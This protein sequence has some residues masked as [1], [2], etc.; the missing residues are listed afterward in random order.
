MRL[1]TLNANL[2]A[3]IAA[4]IAFIISLIPIQIGP[5]FGVSIALVAIHILSFRRGWK[6][7]MLAG[8]IYGILQ[9]ISGFAQI[10]TPIQGIIEYLFAF[11][12]AGFAGFFAIKVQTAAQENNRKQLL[13]QIGLGTFLAVGVE[14]FVHFLAGVYFWGQFA[15]EGMSPWVYSGVMNS[16]SG[17]FTW[18]ACYLVAFLVISTNQKVILAKQ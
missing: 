17:L 1:K 7:G 6:V 12:F 11:I 15:P 2:E 18:L 4:V 16:L 9:F 5:S 3:A 13:L 10:L 8:F 14:Y